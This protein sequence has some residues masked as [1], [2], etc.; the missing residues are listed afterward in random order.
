M[1]VEENEEINAFKK[2][3]QLV[4]R[5]QCEVEDVF[6]ELLYQAHDK[7]EEIQEIR[8]NYLNKIL[9]KRK[10]LYIYPEKVNV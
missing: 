10:N 2:S 7:T 3:N 5:C 8:R 1:S 4:L 6:K 9:E